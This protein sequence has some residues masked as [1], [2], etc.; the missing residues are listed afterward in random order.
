MVKEITPWRPF[1]GLSS[2]RKDMDR[3]WDRFFGEDWG[4]T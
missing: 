2:L 3:L 4:L 1:E